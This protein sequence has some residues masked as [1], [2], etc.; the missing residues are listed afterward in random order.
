MRQCHDSAIDKHEE[1][2]IYVKRKHYKNSSS[3][4]LIRQYIQKEIKMNGKHLITHNP[5]R[6]FIII[7]MSLFVV[8]LE[9]SKAAERTWSN[10][11]GGYFENSANWVG[12][13][14]PG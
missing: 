10:L 2:V 6:L 14:V 3:K 1:N 5:C 9:T 7:I 8:F 13:N 12:G 4:I 11:S